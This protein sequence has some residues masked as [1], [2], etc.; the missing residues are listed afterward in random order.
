VKEFKGTKS[1]IISTTS[2]AGGQNYF[3]SILYLC[4]GSIFLVFA[5]SFLVLQIINPR[6][7]GDHS[8]VKSK[9]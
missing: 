1:I 9:S 7:L 6:K 3:L 8:A 5:I 2:W 4:L